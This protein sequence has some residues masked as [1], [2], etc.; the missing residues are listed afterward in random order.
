MNAMKPPKMQAN[1]PIVGRAARVLHVHLPRIVMR[2]NPSIHSI[3]HQE[4]KSC[5]YA[6]C[7]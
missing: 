4:M 6:R 3:A 7:L 1:D 5:A 2:D